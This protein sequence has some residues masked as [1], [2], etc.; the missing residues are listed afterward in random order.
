MRLDQEV[1]SSN[2]SNKKDGLLG[3]HLNKLYTAENLLQ[4]TNWGI[5]HKIKGDIHP[6]DHPDSKKVQVIRLCKVHVARVATGPSD[7]QNYII[8]QVSTML[9]TPKSVLF[10]GHN[11]L[12]TTGT[13]DLTH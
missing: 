3:S 1:V 2:P 13:D 12:L 8:H 7:A 4:G 5:D 11:H 10:P 6:L 9:A